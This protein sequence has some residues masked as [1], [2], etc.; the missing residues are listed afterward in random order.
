MA[1]LS[2][3]IGA[4]FCIWYH[5]REKVTFST[6][7]DEP[8]GGISIMLEISNLPIFQAIDAY[9]TFN[10]FLSHTSIYV[11]LHSLSKFL[12]PACVADPPS[13]PPASTLFIFESFEFDPILSL[14]TFVTFSWF[15]SWITTWITRLWFRWILSVAKQ[16]SKCMPNMRYWQGKLWQHERKTLLTIFFSILPFNLYFCTGGRLLYYFFTALDFCF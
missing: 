7:S 14:A 6:Y 16:R 3:L 15:R 1:H 2:S 9:L 10:F 13:G 5:S 8:I 12:I 11:G 4:T